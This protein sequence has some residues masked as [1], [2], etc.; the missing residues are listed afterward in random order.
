MAGVI[1][2]LHSHGQDWE[3]GDPRSD[4]T[5]CRGTSMQRSCADMGCGFC[6]AAEWQEQEQ[7]DDMEREARRADERRRLYSDWGQ[8]E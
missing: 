2:Q 6:G 4:C 7:I 3:E 5:T 8:K 1:A